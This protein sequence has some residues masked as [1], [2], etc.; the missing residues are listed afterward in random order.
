MTSRGCYDSSSAGED[1]VA[2]TARSPKESLHAAQIAR[3]LRRARG[4]RCRPLMK[5]R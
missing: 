5:N 2:A 1:A 4:E 3:G